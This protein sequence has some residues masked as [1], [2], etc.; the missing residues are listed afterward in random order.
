MCALMFIMFGGY[1]FKLKEVPFIGVVGESILWWPF[2]GCHIVLIS[3]DVHVW[4]NPTLK[5]WK[6][7]TMFLHIMLKYNL[8]KRL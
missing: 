6:V 2:L 7:F 5:F 4:L 3:K 1:F 8:G